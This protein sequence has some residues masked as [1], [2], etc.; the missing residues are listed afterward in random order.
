MKSYRVSI[1][2]L[3]CLLFFHSGTV[4]AGVTPAHEKT[5]KR[6]EDPGK[7]KKAKK[8]LRKNR[9][10]AENVDFAGILIF[11]LIFS[12]TGLILTGIGAPLSIA[13]L[14]ITGM[15]LLGLTFILSIIEIVSRSDNS[16]NFGQGLDGFFGAMGFL[17]IILLLV[18]AY[19]AIGLSFFIWGLIAAMPVLWISGLLTML[20]IT[21]I[22]IMTSKL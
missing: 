1:F 20:T 18:L 14:W 6:P 17:L 13:A 8:K 10:N 4:L 22:I 12:V 7:L 16:V 19:T 3:F 9:T 21:S 5:E 2:V 15:A 11:Q